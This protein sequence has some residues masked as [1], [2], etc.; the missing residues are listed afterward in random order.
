MLQTR[1]FRVPPVLLLFY[2]HADARPLRPLAT[3]LQVFVPAGPAVRTARQRP[4]PDVLLAVPAKAKKDVV[5]VDELHTLG[6][7]RPAVPTRLIEAVDTVYTNIQGTFARP[8]DIQRL[9][10]LVVMLTSAAVPLPYAVAATA[11]E[12]PRPVGL[13]RHN[14]VA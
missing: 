9:T 2:L 8:V 4:L 13:V 10:V 11:L 12:V 7:D 1:P 5:A 3:S 14:A 6:L